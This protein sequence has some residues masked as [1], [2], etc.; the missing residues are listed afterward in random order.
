MANPSSAMFHRLLL[1]YM[2]RG[3]R[4]WEYPNLWIV[5]LNIHFP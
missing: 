4:E 5:V 1:T 2:Q 3:T